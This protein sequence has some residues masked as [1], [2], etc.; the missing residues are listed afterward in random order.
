MYINIQIRGEPVHKRQ[1]FDPSGGKIK[2]VLL[3]HI[4]T[5]IF[6]HINDLHQV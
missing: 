6:D 3:K 5:N 4:Q 1:W 2:Y